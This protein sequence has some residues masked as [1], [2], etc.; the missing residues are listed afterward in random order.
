MSYINID[1][2]KPKIHTII[3]SKGSG[4]TNLV[5]FLLNKY[6]LHKSIDSLV[7]FCGSADESYN[8]YFDEDLICRNYSNEKLENL[9]TKQRKL[10]D[11]SKLVIVFDDI[12]GD[13]KVNFQYNNSIE[14]L[15]T[16]H[17]HDNVSLI[18][19]VQSQSLGSIFREQSDYIYLLRP[20]FYGQT[21]ENIYN[22]VGAGIEKKKF[23]NMLKEIFKV[24]YTILLYDTT[25]Q[26]NKEYGSFVTPLM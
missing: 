9:L 22:V 15:L 17:R 20:K 6:V 14:S 21:I 5:L 11:D 12:V 24:N 19:S 18:L 7:I 13:K 4:K 16:I 3:A 1:I 10:N 23:V 26:E 8:K 2:T 25:G